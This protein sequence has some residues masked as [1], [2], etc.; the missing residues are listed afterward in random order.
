MIFRNELQNAIKEYFIS[1][2][3][4][5][6]QMVEITEANA[7]IQKIIEELDANPWNP[8]EE[9]VPMDERYVLLSFENFTLPQIGRY[10]TD[11]DGGGSFF[12][13]DDDKSL[14]SYGLFVNAWMDL[15]ERYKS[16]ME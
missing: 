11:E 2:I 3:D 6:E 16:D 10:E 9:S 1:K 7:D 5:K 14:A 12:L 15:P 8:V 4:N 13:G